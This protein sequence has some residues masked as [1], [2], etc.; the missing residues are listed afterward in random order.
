[1]EKKEIFELLK[2]FGLSDYESLAYASLVF[3][4]P[5]KASEISKKA[6]I[7]QSKIYDVLNKL[8]E[9]EMVDFIG[10][11]PKEFKALPPEIALRNLLEE[12]KKEIEK[13]NEKIKIL[14]KFLRPLPKEEVL[15]GV[16][17]T[18]GKGLRNFINRVCEMFDKAKEYAYV[19]TRDFT[20]ASSLAR[21][22]E[23]C[24]KRGVIIRTIT[25]KEIDSSNYWRAKWYYSHG[26]QIKIFKTRVHPR[27]IVVDGKEVL[28]RLDHNPTKRKRFRFTSIYS[29]DP[30]LAKVFDV[31]VKMLWKRAE[32]VNFKSLKL[33]L[34][35][36]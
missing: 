15:E 12:K 9:K 20:W 22:V 18:K 16:W 35:E 11:R 21:A 2:T 17:T 14:S 24:N 1:M 33:K 26:V 30:S 31:Y 19:I 6:N 4:G 5:S 32:P 29:T 10:G 27:I 34:P 3:I 25:M 28:I 8:I 7:P 13:L 36:G 23:D